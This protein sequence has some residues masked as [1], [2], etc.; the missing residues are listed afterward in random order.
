MLLGVIVFSWSVMGSGCTVAFFVPPKRSRVRPPIYTTVWDVTRRAYFPDKFGWVVSV[1]FHMPGG[2]S[3]EVR[4][5]RTVWS[6]SIAVRRDVFSQVGGFRLDFCTVGDNPKPEDT[7]VCIRM[8]K[9]WPAGTWVFVPGAIVDHEVGPERARFTFFLG[10]CFLEGHSKVQLARLNSGAREL[11]DEYAYVW[12][13]LRGGL[14]QHV[15]TGFRKRDL[16][17]IERAIAVASGL[18]AAGL[19]AAISY[20]RPSRAR[21]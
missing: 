10:R 3:S 15:A 12:E 17:S 14:R 20:A 5:A 21:Q 2:P 1:T 9:A 13:T 7:D 18:T 8:S 19:G 16:K 6:E 11:S 4:G